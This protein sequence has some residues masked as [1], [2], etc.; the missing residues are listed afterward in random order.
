MTSFLVPTLRRGNAVKPLQRRESGWMT[1]DAGTSGPAPTRERGRQIG[2]P[3]HQIDVEFSREQ[4][5][6][7]GFA[8]ETL[9]G[10]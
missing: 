2:L 10:G 6:V 3:I 8:V 9:A 4:R 1:E 7:V 5:G